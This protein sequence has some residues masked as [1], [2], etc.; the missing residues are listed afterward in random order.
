MATAQEWITAPPNLMEA[1]VQAGKYEVEASADGF[2]P[3]TDQVEVRAGETKSLSFVLE[4]SKKSHDLKSWDEP[5]KQSRWT[6]KQDWNVLKGSGGEKFVVY[7]ITPPTGEFTFLWW[8]QEGAPWVKGKS[9][10]WVINLIDEKNYHYFALEGNKLVRYRV[11]DGRED[12]HKEYP[13][14]TGRQTYLLTI[15]VTRD[16]ILTEISDRERKAVIAHDDW[17]IPEYNASAGKFAFDVHGREEVWLT[18][19]T[20]VQKHP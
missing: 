5:G 19:W 13:M 2:I 18:G 4:S 8:K 15:T 7:R 20:F 17:K 10:R 16:G 6:V 12:L 3:A 11:R 14:Q 9:L 1:N